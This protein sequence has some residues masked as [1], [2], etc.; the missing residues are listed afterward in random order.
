MR[1]L[2]IVAH[3]PISPNYVG[4]ASAMYYDQLLALSELG[5]EIHLWHFAS[6]EARER[7]SRFVDGEPAVWETVKKRCQSIQL[8]SCRNGETLLGRG[9]ARLRSWLPPG[10][11]VSR[12]SLYRELQQL[13]K[14]I[15]PD[16][17]WAQH[18]EPAML[19]AQQTR[20][21]VVYVHHDWL[22]RIKALRNHRAINP[23][24]QAVEERLVR[25]VSAVVS[26]SK[27]ECKEI[28]LAG[29]RNVH[30]IP[31][32]FDLVPLDLERGGDKSPRLVHLGGMGTTANREG[33]LAFFE[34]VWPALKGTGVE[35]EVIGDTAGAS[36]GLQEHLRTVKCSGFIKDLT[37]V[38]RPFDIHVIPWEHTTGQ[39]TRLPV[40][41]NHA[42]VVVATRAAVACY[43]EAR[44]RENCRLVNRLEDMISVIPELMADH[45]E[46]SRL[47]RAA[48]ATFE[49]QFT[50]TSLLPRY[51][52]VLGALN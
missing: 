10:L 5:H 26:G 37:T 6:G 15:N 19:A 2:Y 22:Y 31:V 23:R 9:L 13:I 17:I 45:G 51:G 44:D 27:P 25:S 39:R 30:Y 32:S 47:G 1:C 42:Q 8:S 21:P 16:V 11:P 38:L 35:F 33:L 48:R 36:S 40:A 20:V 3:D 14:R 24:Q 12:W 46:R 41:F 29:G 28:S 18:F 43:P 52:E 4:G 34:R 50:C 7:F 49:K